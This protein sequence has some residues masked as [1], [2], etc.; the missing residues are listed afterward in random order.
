MSSMRC[1]GCKIDFSGTQRCFSKH[2]LIKTASCLRIGDFR[3]PKNDD[4][5]DDDGIV[6]LMDFAVKKFSRLR[7]GDLRYTKIFFYSVLLLKFV[8]ASGEAILGTQRYFSKD[9]LIPTSFRLWVLKLASANTR[10]VAGYKIQNPA[11]GCPH[12]CPHGFLLC[13]SMFWIFRFPAKRFEVHNDVL[14]TVL[15]QF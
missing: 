10:G 11:A 15:V 6:F 7:R 14:R 1:L 5:D 8:R 4:D 2:F 9:A 13:C 3:P 12:G